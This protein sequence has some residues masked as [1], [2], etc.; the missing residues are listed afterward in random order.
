M[1]TCV[2]RTAVSEPGLPSIRHEIETVLWAF[3]RD[4]VAAAAGDRLSD[5][6]PRASHD[7][8]F[9]GGCDLCCA[10]S[11]GTPRTARTIAVR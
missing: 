4:K 8:L 7:F 5:E 6:I 3:M 1:T 2:A 9:A 11:A 10:C